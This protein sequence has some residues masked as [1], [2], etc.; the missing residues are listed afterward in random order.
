MVFRTSI[1][2]LILACVGILTPRRVMGQATTIDT[3]LPASPG[4]G[5]SSLGPAPGSGANTL[6]T[7]PGSGGSALAQPASG[8]IS[9]RLGTATTRA[10]SAI[11]TPAA[12]EGGNATGM[13]YRAPQPQPAPVGERYGSFEITDKDDEGPKDGLTLDQAIDRVVHENLD[14]RSKFLEIPQAEAD[15]LNANLRANPVFYA[16]SQLIPYGKF[17]RSSPGGPT[18]YDVNISYPFDLSRKRQA[19]TNYA[20]TAKR[21]IEAQYQDAVRNRI[22]DVY[23]AYT[24]VLGARQTVRFARTSVEGM[25]KFVEVTRLL[26]EREQATRADV[27]RAN[28]RLSEAEVGLLDAEENLRKTKR[29]LGTLLNMTPEESESLE[30]RGSIRVEVPAVPPMEELVQ[31]ALAVRPDVVSF[32]LG[33]QSAEA[34]VRL[35]KANRFTDVY[36][37]YQPYTFQNNQPYGLKSPISWALGVTVPLPVY[38]RNQ[39]GIERA[40]L[41]VTQSRL[42]VETLERQVITDVQQA[43]HE[44]DITKEMVRRIRQT[45]EPNA[46]LARNDSYRLYVG[47]EVNQLT[48]LDAQRAYNDTAKQYLDTVVRHRKSMLSLNTALGQRMLP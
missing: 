7:T 16:D 32:R 24:D 15:I 25:K 21:V 4:G 19:R 18:Q 35:Q 46:R 38:N 10:P 40:K 12:G 36:V 26:Y 39:G 9:G 8:I 44:Y 29:V 34:N 41:N 45:V 37:L 6:G 22:D 27:G 17:N 3:G 23:G 28:V 33:V 1:L 13:G 43:F 5:S 11:S 47:G 30:V 20:S 14:L 48:Y 42:E 2:L 31:T